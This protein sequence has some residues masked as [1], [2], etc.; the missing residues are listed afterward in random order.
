MTPPNNSSPLELPEVVLLLGTYLSKPDLVKCVRV[1]KT[2]NAALKPY[3]W[4][5]LSLD[6]EK[7]RQGL[8]LAPLER[9]RHFIHSITTLFIEDFRRL[10]PVCPNLKSFDISLGFPDDEMII[11]HELEV[12][13]SK[14]PS[15]ISIQ[16]RNFIVDWSLFRNLVNI[17]H[18]SLINC[19]ASRFP[20][21]LDVY[22]GQLCSNR[23]ESLKLKLV[24]FES[25]RNQDLTL[26]SL[27]ELVLDRIR[28]TPGG[29]E[30]EIARRCPNLESFTLRLKY[31]NSEII[32]E[33]FTNLV[34][35]GTWPKLQKL[36][37][38]DLWIED[39]DLAKI[40]QSMTCCK[41]LNMPGTKF[42]YRSFQVLK[43]HYGVLTEVD[44]I[45]SWDSTTKMIPE[46]LA[47]CPR[48]LAFRGHDI[49]AE[50]IAKGP[51]WVCLNLRTLDVFLDFR[52]QTKGN[53]QKHGYSVLQM[54]GTAMG[55]RKSVELQRTVFKQISRL[56]N[57]RILSIGSGLGT[58]ERLSSYD[59]GL[60]L[61]LEMGL[62]LLCTLRSLE[63]LDFY[64]VFQIMNM[65]EIEWM[66]RN[67]RCLDRVTG[68]F[69]FR[70]GELC[71]DLGHLLK[72]KDI[73]V[74]K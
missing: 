53:N 32:V 2:W 68:M 4:D 14:N 39:E 38:E 35:A 24:S 69:N 13:F 28:T 44:L 71:A 16:I 48:L 47:S 15:V 64:K 10:V 50:D 41:R 73:E 23:L 36:N 57:L 72:T 58:I 60:D 65:R 52:P 7:C 51:P 20:L 55:D 63:I 61:R 25:I 70:D 43:Q 66:L 21:D 26:H 34:V 17:K 6:R 22:L 33:A 30:L 19:K 45:R 1:S 37:C 27:R 12:L 40:I 67:W 11:K 74:L 8:D 54:M 18:L 3:L 5:Q 56:K 31:E 59:L 9:N 46:I 49:L 42:G 62:G 29:Q